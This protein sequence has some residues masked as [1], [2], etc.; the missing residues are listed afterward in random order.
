MAPSPPPPQPP[1]LDAL[2]RSAAFHNTV[3]VWV[4]ACSERGAR[5]DD[6]AGYGRLV[7]AL[8]EEGVQM[9]PFGLC[10][11][12]EEGGGDHERAKAAFARA[13]KE[14]FEGLEGP[15][16]G[17]HSVRLGDRAVDAARRCAASAAGADP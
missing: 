1:T 13:A 15:P 16:P 5:W 7:K 9:R 2:R 14:G 11:S 8:A 17:V 4:S 12:D 3:D 6:G 10:V